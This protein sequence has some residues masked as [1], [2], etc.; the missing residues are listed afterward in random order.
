[1]NHKQRIVT[2]ASVAILT[3][4]LFFV[5]WRVNDVRGDYYELSE[6]WHPVIYD[7]GGVMP[8]VLLYREWGVLG[9][10]YVVL[11]VCLKSK[12]KQDSKQPTSHN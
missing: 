8:P 5:P 9:S 7:E 3:L 12:K 10:A 2:Y 1:M 11:I 4:S 6:Y